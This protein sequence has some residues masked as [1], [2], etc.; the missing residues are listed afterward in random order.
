MRAEIID[1]DFPKGATIEPSGFLQQDV[2]NI[3]FGF[4]IFS[5]MLF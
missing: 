1:G 3:S 2:E 4:F 5:A